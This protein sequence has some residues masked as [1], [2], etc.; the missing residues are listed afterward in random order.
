M[1]KKYKTVQSLKV[2]FLEHSPHVQLYTGASD[3]KD[4]GNIPGSHFVKGFSG[5]PSYS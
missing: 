4:V 2:H 1:P 5:P 3:G